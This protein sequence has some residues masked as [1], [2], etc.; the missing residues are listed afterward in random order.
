MVSAIG[1]EGVPR[2][3][4]LIQPLLMLLFV[5]VSRALPRIWLGGIYQSHS[6]RAGQPRV[7]I[8]GAGSA[9]RQLAAA[10]KTSSE[11]DLV[12]LLDDDDRLHGQ[13][14]NGLKIYAPTDVVA[15]VAQLHVNQVYLAIPSA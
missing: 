5:G 9:G 2:T 11:V 10:I 3:I 14:L 6:L 1:I 12:G 13:V 8:Y 15:L 4:G 7:L